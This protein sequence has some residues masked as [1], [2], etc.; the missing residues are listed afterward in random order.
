MSTTQET[1]KSYNTRNNPEYNPQF[2]GDSLEQM[3]ETFPGMWDDSIDPRK[4]ERKRIFK[5]VIKTF[6]HL[7]IKNVIATG[8]AYTLPM[9]VGK[10]TV[11]KIIP[12]TKA[13]DFKKTKELGQTVYHTN[14]HSHGYKAFYKWIKSQP[15]SFVQ[16]RGLYKFIPSKTARSQLAYAIRENNTILNYHDAT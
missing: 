2:W 12:K 5:E 1:P 16:N 15:H 3:W 4:N 11:L 9:K 7:L 6:N 8:H 10:L 13:V 14:R